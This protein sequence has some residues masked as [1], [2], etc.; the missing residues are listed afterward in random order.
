MLWYFGIKL[1]P[2]DP[3]DDS[4]KEQ[5]EEDL[6]KSS[7]RKQWWVKKINKF[8]EDFLIFKKK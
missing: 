7:S 3:E 5:R 6:K 2:E 8:V 1:T 4:T